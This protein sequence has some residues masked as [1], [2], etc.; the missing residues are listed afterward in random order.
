M[1]D[2]KKVKRSE[3][4]TFLNVQPSGAAS[5]VRMGKGITSQS[6]SYN[7]QTS[8]ET[9]IDEDSGNTNVDSY[10]PTINSPQ[11]AYKGDPV[12]DY[13]DELRQKRAVGD[14]CITD[15]LMVYIYDSKEG[16]TYAAEK[17]KVAIQI[18]EFGGDGGGNTSITYTIN[19]IGDAVRGTATIN[20][21]TK[22]ATFTA[23]E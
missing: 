3:F 12:F 18:D 7:A 5:F 10:A 15:L 11:T 4:A 20:T 19:F 2:A 23:A 14:E 1:A 17:Q 8:Q 16:T 6:V 9:Y 13:V 21:E 22:T